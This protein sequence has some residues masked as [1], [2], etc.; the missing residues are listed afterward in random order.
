M[1]TDG[2]AEL[3]P[4]FGEDLGRVSASVSLSDDR[5]TC[6]R[7]SSLSTSTPLMLTKPKSL[8]VDPIEFC[9]QDLSQAARSAERCADS[10]AE[11][12]VD[13]WSCPKATGVTAGPRPER[14][15]KS[16]KQAWAEGET[17]S[18]S[19][20]EPGLRGLNGPRRE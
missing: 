7:V 3:T 11:H 6:A 2:L 18:V 13:V 4:V 15:A 16:G 19:S 12:S 10:P 8:V 14:R 20:A 1:I 17:T 9:G 5:K